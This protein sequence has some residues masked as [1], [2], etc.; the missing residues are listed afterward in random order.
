[1]P[2]THD[3]FSI[4]KAVVTPPQ[5]YRERTPDRARKAIGFQHAPCSVLLLALM[6]ARCWLTNLGVSCKYTYRC[7]CYCVVLTTLFRWSMWTTG[8]KHLSHQWLMS[9]ALI[10]ICLGEFFSCWSLATIFLLKPGLPTLCCFPIVEELLPKTYSMSVPTHEGHFWQAIMSPWQS[11]KIENC[12]TWRAEI[13]L[14]TAHSWK[15][16]WQC[17]RN[18]PDT[19]WDL[20]GGDDKW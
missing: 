15:A 3:F 14:N 13:L 2:L 6:A 12:E 10:L 18:E 20:S 11:A 5:S 17:H 4:G 8:V 19:S 7:N 9:F 16:L 1:V